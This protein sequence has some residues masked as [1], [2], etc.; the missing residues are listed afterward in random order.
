MFLDR[1]RQEQQN[2]EYAAMVSSVVGSENE[3]FAFGIQANE[4]KQ[5]QGHIVTIFNIGLSV[6]AVFT[7]VYMGSRTMTDDIGIV[8]TNKVVK[9]AWI[10]QLSS[11]ACPTLACWSIDYCYSRNSFIYRLCTKS[12]STTKEVQVNKVGFLTKRRDVLLLF[13]G[14]YKIYFHNI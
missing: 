13:W 3:R 4:L 12:I 8:S 11:L 6:A 10:T 14:P 2:R 7:A 1:L 5:V 9:M